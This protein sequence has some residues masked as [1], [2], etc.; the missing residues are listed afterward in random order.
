MVRLSFALSGSGTGIGVLWRPKKGYKCPIP[1]AKNKAN[2]VQLLIG[3]LSDSVQH[4][5]AVRLAILRDPL[6]KRVSY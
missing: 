1:H 5:V 2:C 3:R 4:L 6:L